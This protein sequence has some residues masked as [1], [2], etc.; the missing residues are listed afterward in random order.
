VDWTGLLRDSW[1]IT[2]RTPALWGLGVISALQ[3]GVYT[4]IV[5]GLI[6]PMTALT[7]VLAAVGTG[8]AAGDSAGPLATFVPGVVAWIQRWTPEL[9]VGIVAIVAVWAVLG[10]LDVA[11][12]A[13][14]ITQAVLAE[15][16]Y[17]TSVGAGMR[18]GFG[19]WW[20][21]IGLLALGALPA[22]CYLLVAAIFTLFTISIPL[23]M[24]QAPNF[25]A[26]RA[27][28]AVNAVVSSV[29]GLIGI[30]LAVLVNLG[31]RPVVLEGLQ[32]KPAFSA[33]W[34]LA[35]RNLADVAIMYLLQ[36]ALS[37]VL[38]FAISLVMG[39]LG[40][41]A[42]S[43]VAVMVASAHAFSGG[44]M[45]VTVMTTVIALPILLVYSVVAIVWFSVLWTL[46]WRRL[47]R[48]EQLTVQPAYRLSGAGVAGQGEAL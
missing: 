20:R 29:V 36:T 42:G 47:T 10:A 38:G 12:T 2:R 4:L 18:D 44:A 17:E 3:V 14:T 6:V 9:V 31:L 15:D 1:R 13:G 7:Q 32:W 46:F 39:V 19:A 8:A 33:A 23:S 25:S 40:A 27:G 35:R 11:A 45:F 30:P 34:G 43:I 16:G 5:A 21:T 22:L 26:I 48:R 28:D 41:V 24:G 37:L